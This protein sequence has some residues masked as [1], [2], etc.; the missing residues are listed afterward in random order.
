MLLEEWPGFGGMRD[1]ENSVN[2]GRKGAN[3]EDLRDYII[4]G[5]EWTN[6]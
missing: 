3:K 2:N 1:K 6:R 5:G 4:L